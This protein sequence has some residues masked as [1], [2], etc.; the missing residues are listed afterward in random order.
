MLLFEVCVAGLVTKPNKIT[1]KRVV[2][3]TDYGDNGRKHT[4]KPRYSHVGFAAAVVVVVV[5][6]PGR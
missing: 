2:Y 1:S 5:Q 3:R 6:L 4:E